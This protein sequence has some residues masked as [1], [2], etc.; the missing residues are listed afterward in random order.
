MRK[1]AAEDSCGE[2]GRAVG[3]LFIPFYNLYW[4]FQALA[5]FAKDFNAF[6][7]RHSIKARP[8]SPGLFV[9]CGILLILAAVPVLDIFLLPALS[10]VALVMVARICDAVNCVPRILPAAASTP[11]A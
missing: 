7:R 6:G 8:L 5:G 1:E 9:A 11:G 10:V 3:F 4:I 2:G